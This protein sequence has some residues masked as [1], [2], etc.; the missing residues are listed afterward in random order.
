MSKKFFLFIGLAISLFSYGQLEFKVGQRPEIDT[1]KAFCTYSISALNQRYQ[2][3]PKE[4][5]SDSSEVTIMVV[6]GGNINGQ[7]IAE[8]ELVCDKSV[9][10]RR[11][12]QP[13]TFKQLQKVSFDLRASHILFYPTTNKAPYQTKG[14]IYNAL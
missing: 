1:T 14:V 4:T 10:Y 7:V 6:I 9:Q 13:D 5:L 8:I 3:I 12:F 11:D 2:P